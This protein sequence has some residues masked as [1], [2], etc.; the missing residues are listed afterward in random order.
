VLLADGSRVWCQVTGQHRDRHGRCVGIRWY[1]SP[2]IGG[3]E[4]WFLYRAGAIRRVSS[5]PHLLVRRHG[6]LFAY[7]AGAEDLAWLGVDVARLAV[8]RRWYVLPPARG[9]GE[10]SG[11]PV[12]VPGGGLQV[13]PQ[14]RAVVTRR[15]CCQFRPASACSH[16]RRTLCVPRIPSMALTSEV[17]LPVT[18]P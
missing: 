10:G 7:V 9:A 5:G 8:G 15:A 18:R 16:T 14:G 1:A 11:H 13:R 2:S 4:G 6:F 3:R 17:A 12:C